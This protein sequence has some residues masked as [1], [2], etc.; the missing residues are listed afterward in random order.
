[1]MIARC[2]A[3][4]TVFRV[5]PDQLRAQHGNVRCGL[6]YATFNAIDHLIEDAGESA[7][8]PA[9]APEAR[10]PA[11]PPTPPADPSGGEYFVLEERPSESG[12]ETR[13]LPFE[14]AGSSPPTTPP[15]ESSFDLLADRLDF[16][17]PDSLLPP[18]S[19]ASR[20]RE[21]PAGPS[22]RGPDLPVTRPAPEPSLPE[23]I[24]LSDLRPGPSPDR[25][26]PL[27]PEAPDDAE[28]VPFGEWARRI[29]SAPTGEPDIGLVPRRLDEAPSPEPPPGRTADYPPDTG[30]VADAPGRAPPELPLETGVAP[31]TSPWPEEALEAERL[32]ATYGPVPAGRRWLLGLGLGLLLGTLLVQAAY[33]FREEITRTWP[34]LRPLYLAACAQLGCTVPLPRVAGAISIETSDLQ[35]EPGHATRFVLNATVRNRAAHPQAYP[36]LELTLTDARDRPVVRR[37][38]APADWVPENR[39]DGGF[40]PTQEI[41]LKLPFEAPGIEAVGY[42]MYAFYP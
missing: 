13:P 30:P 37:V 12:P 1:M 17:I 16:E 35:S 14:S 20:H 32:D 4:Q 5:R 23:F 10:E 38:L 21:P 3:C 28:R 11:S 18:R 22:A 41:V 8:P 31:R 42:R 25:V 7:S 24:D 27:A 9:P 26:Q 15:H 34:P 6:C 39:L 19:S 36:H 40:P 2:P 33:L 29:H